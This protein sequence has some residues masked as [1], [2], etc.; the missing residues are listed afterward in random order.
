MHINGDMS[1]V[2]RFLSLA[3]L[4]GE[5]LSFLGVGALESQCDELYATT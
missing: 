2:L 5:P 4:M 1:W 3:F